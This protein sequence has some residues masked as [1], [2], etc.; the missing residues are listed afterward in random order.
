MEENNKR[1]LKNT[2]YL[3]IRQFV[4][5]VLGLF[6][7]RIVL[8]KLG[9]A[10]Y[11]LYNLVAGFIASFVV[12]DSILSASTR[13]FIGLY[14]GKNDKEKLQKTFST[15][16]ALQ[17]VIS[18]IILIA[19]E[20]FGIWFLNS[21]L[22]IAPDRM[23][24]ANWVFQLGVVG[25]ILGILQTPF[26]AIVTA[27]E[28]FTIYAVFS[29]LDVV[30]KIAILFL[31]V[32]IPGDKL[33]IYSILN[34]SV[35]IIGLIIYQ[36]YSIKNFE[37]CRWRFSIDRSLLKEMLV[38]SGWGVLG[39]VISVV[40]S[41]G[42]S[43]ILNIFFNTVMN[44]ARG[45]AMT[46]NHIITQFVTG[47]I[48]AA[49]P[50]LVK[51]YGSGEMDKFVRLIFNV[52]QLTLFLL[53]LFLV[54]C[55]FEV[56]YV[57]GLWLGDNVPEYTCKFVKITLFLGLIYRTNIMVEN[58]LHAI[59]RVKENNMYSVPVYLLSIPIVYLV[60]KLGYSPVVMYWF[61]SIPPLLSFLINIV[62][63]SKYS[64]FPGRK[65]F[66]EIFLKNIALVLIS[67]ILPFIVQ[68]F[69]EP[70]LVRFLTVCTVS[71]IST[72]AVIWVLGMNATTKEMFVN[73]LRT[74]ILSKFKRLAT[75]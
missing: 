29:I 8:D 62:L 67:A 28:H 10:D 37:E 74:K 53:A 32:Y 51:Y 43:I 45:L 7:T 63:L 31:L 65:F 34:L 9:V 52:T 49:Q 42:I 3:Y 12:L 47:F 20:T 6:T 66:F 36:F 26:V 13:R 59:G 11:G 33:I 40:N 23:I 60:L 39:H 25:V 75:N 73:I 22:N 55:L 35:G 24:A 41:Q 14:I 15:A 69:M 68:K 18:A 56:D 64:V 4:I 1:I 72:F 46:V 71:V 54:P 21:K 2:V 61:A 44:A 19:L 16:L 50:Q 17:V 57:I 30:F 38:F 27:Y 48:V 70:G 5:L 58:G